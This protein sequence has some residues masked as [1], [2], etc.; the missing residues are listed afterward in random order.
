[1]KESLSKNVK[2]SDKRD[3]ISDIQTFKQNQIRLEHIETFK[4][5]QSIVNLLKINYLESTNPLYK[6]RNLHELIHDL[7]KD[8]TS[9]NSSKK[10]DQE[11]KVKIGILFETKEMNPPYY[12]SWEF[13]AGTY[14]P[15]LAPFFITLF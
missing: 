3:K 5:F 6:G 12:F 2:I 13:T 4:D 9:S 10:V 1:M 7:R 8:L 14:L 15:I 11:I